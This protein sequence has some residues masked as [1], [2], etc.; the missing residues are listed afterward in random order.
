[1]KMYLDKWIDGESVYIFKDSQKYV[2][3]NTDDVKNS[4]EFPNE[5]YEYKNRS[6]DPRPELTVMRHTFT[7]KCE[8][9]RFGKGSNYYV[10]TSEE[11]AVK[12]YIEQKEMFESSALIDTNHVIVLYHGHLSHN[13]FDIIPS[14]ID[15]YKEFIEVIDWE[16]I[17]VDSNGISTVIR[18]GFGSIDRSNIEIKS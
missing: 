17:D 2:F 12:W 6:L 10:F 7:D 3:W 18:P 4:T 11:E 15:E 1:M 8:D 14:R 16:E 13:S 5:L 9:T